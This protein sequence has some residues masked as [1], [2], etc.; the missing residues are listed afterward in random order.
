VTPC[1]LAHSCCV[2]QFT[3]K[4]RV[5][6]IA[7]FLSGRCALGVRGMRERMPQLGVLEVR[8]DPNGTVVVATFPHADPA[9]IAASEKVA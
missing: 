9:A 1:S 2:M 4:N 7:P 8:S 6:L 5:V 3:R